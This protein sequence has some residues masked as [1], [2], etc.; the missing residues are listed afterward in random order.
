[1]KKLLLLLFLPSIV[2][3]QTSVNYE[4]TFQSVWNAGHHGTLPGSAH[5]SD[6]V[7]A[8]HNDQITFW[9]IGGFASPGIEDVAELGQNTDFFNE[10]NEAINPLVGSPTADQWLQQGFS[11]FAA[12]SSSTLMTVNVH[13]DFPLITLATMVAPSPDWFSGVS[14]Y[15]LKN[16]DGSW[17]TTHSVP[18]FVYDAGTEDGMAYSLS[19]AATSPHVAISVRNMF[20]FNGVYSQGDEKVGDI[21]F[22]LLSQLDVED[23]ENLKSVTISPNPTNGLTT[24]SNLNRIANSLD[25][26]DILG[27]R[28]HTQSIENLDSVDLDLHLKSGIYLVNIKSD[29]GVESRK[30]IIN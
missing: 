3:T 22:T 13:E 21:T 25:I 18:V 2:I 12:I 23:F 26:Y 7:G 19:N 24:I 9:E 1:M 5:W 17:K 29:S 30:L 15:S 20:L 6:F 10:V 16:P 8:T 14:G 4:I 27:K 11:P 28:V